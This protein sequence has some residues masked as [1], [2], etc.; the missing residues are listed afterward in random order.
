[1]K[2]AIVSS[3]L[4]LFFILGGCLTPQPSQY[5]TKEPLR[6]EHPISKV[7]INGQTVNVELAISQED[8]LRGLSNRESLGADQGMLF[9]FP[10]YAPRSFWMKDMQIPLDIIWI[11]DNQIVGIAYSV[12]TAPPLIA[13]HSPEPVNYVLEVNA[14]WAKSFSVTTR[15]RVEYR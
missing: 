14:G 10:D 1:M 12:A 2:L 8:R 3:F 9:V 7:V 6:Y 11:K 13:Y 5:Q 15:T 4:I